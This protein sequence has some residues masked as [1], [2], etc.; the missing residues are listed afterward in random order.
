LLLGQALPAA[1]HG[2]GTTASNYL[3]RI[4]RA[5]DIDGVTFAIIGG[6]Q[7]LQVTNTS[8]TVLEVPGYEDVLVAGDNGGADPYLRIGPQ[9]VE[10]NQASRATYLNAD[11]FGRPGEPPPPGVG[12]DQPPHWV[13]VSSAPTYAWHDHRIHWMSPTLPPVIKDRTEQTL[14][15]AWKVVFTHGGTTY[16]VQGELW[17]VPGPSPVP[18]F[19]LAVL[20]TAPAL[21]GLARIR[22]HGW[23]A[24]VARPAAVV[25]LVVSLGNVVH[26]VDD[27]LALPRPLTQSLPAAVQTALFIGMGVLGAVAAWRG[28]AGAFTA[29]G[30]GAGAI[31]V[32][33]GLLYLDPLRA[34][35]TTTVFPDELTRLAI[36]LS[37][38]QVVPVGLISVLGGRRLAAPDPAAPT[39]TVDPSWPQSS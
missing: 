27:L 7:Y 36:A 31:F 33:Q 34:S 9:G 29:L 38:V 22:R 37:L 21:A 20:L 28:R 1:A 8:D 39:G 26:L 18:W 32:G 23:D 30:V 14:I 13:T 17:W 6:D 10:V 11:R 19:T 35:G 15:S 16:E 24:R 5:P 2:R 25:L 12:K 3:S 4:T